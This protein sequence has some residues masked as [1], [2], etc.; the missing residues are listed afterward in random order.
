MMS[1]NRNTRYASPFFTFTL[2]VGHSSS[3]IDDKKTSICPFVSRASDL[4]DRAHCL[5]RC[6][7]RYCT[8]HKYSAVHLRT[9]ATKPYKLYRK[10]QCCTTVRCNSNVIALSAAGHQQA[11]VLVESTRTAQHSTVHRNLCQVTNALLHYTHSGCTTLQAL[12]HLRLEST[13]NP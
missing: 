11:C 10:L 3:Q 9:V 1:F 4:A 13:Q 6:Q 8:K 12:A 2:M 5:V 7:V